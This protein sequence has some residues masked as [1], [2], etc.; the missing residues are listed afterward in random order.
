MEKDNIPQYVRIAI[1]LGKEI[2]EG[3]YKEGK[4][5][6]GLSKLAS[7]YSV[8]TETVRK[9]MQLLADMNIILLQEKKNAVVQ[10]SKQAEYY[11]K[12]LK[13]RKERYELSDRM[14]CLFKNYQEIGKELEEVSSRLLDSLAYP[15]PSEQ[16]IPTF[17]IAVKI[18]SEKIGRTI[19]SIKFWQ[20]TGSTVIAIRR[21]QSIIVSPGPYERFNEGDILV[22]VGNPGC[23]NLVEYYINTSNDRSSGNQNDYHSLWADHVNESLREEMETI[24]NNICEYLKCKPSD[25][26]HIMPMEQGLNNHSFSFECKGDKY[27]Y[28][29]PGVNSV[30]VVNREKESIAL[31]T[32]KRLGVD[33]TLLYIDEKTGWKLSRFVTVTE[34]FSF[35]NKKHVKMLASHIKSLNESG[36]KLGFVF[37]Y[38]K[39]SNQLIQVIKGANLSKYKKALKTRD[40]VKPAFDILKKDPWQTGICHNDLYEPNLLVEGDKLHII[41]WEFAGDSDIGFDICKIF[42]SI[43]PKYEDLDEWLSLYYDKP[44]SADRKCHL[45]SCAA[46]IYY[47]WYIWGLYAD[48]NGENVADYITIWGDRMIYYINMLK[49]I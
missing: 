45:I 15:M 8:S 12:S 7:I 41:D 43:T 32:A 1:A 49:E 22:C 19:G 31:K 24:Q 6:P 21:G 23:E 39:E 13:Y 20:A 47:Y 42:A 18:G 27:V 33:D 11:L 26:N 30:D 2:A 48:E 5:L 17:E 4:K 9:S 35:F 16:M 14:K 28:R 3:T 25:I 46:V 44:L 40:F 10:S 34:E 29:H 38:E 37:D 36:E